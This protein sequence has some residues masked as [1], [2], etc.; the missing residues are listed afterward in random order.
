MHIYTVSNQM[1]NT[2]HHSKTRVPDAEIWHV[3]QF[4]FLRAILETIA[5]IQLSSNTTHPMLLAC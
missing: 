3:S 5:M 2:C 4:A 1:R